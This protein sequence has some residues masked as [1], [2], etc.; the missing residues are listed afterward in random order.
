MDRQVSVK[1]DAQLQTRKDK[2]FSYMQ[3]G[4]ELA[5]LLDVMQVSGLRSDMRRLEELTT[6]I[7]RMY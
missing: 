7:K 6:A 4:K 1:F 3:T 2:L 5:K